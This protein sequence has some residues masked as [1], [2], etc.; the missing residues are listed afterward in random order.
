MFDFLKK[1]LP[2]S[3]ES[4]SPNELEEILKDGKVRLLDVR[5]PQEYRGGHIRQ[6]RNFPLDQIQTYKGPKN[7]KVYAICQS[8]M[9]SKRAAS[10]LKAKGYEAVN[11][12]GGMSAYQGKRIGGI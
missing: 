11:V 3:S 7:G 9:R 12:R 4:V 6:A 8:G 2:Q 10:I 1:L 5:S